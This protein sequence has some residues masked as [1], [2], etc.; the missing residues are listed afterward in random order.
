[1]G[2]NKVTPNRH[3][4]VQ[5]TKLT[6]TKKLYLDGGS[7][8]YIV[9]SLA[10]AVGFVVGGATL[11]LLDE[12]GS[13]GNVVI[14]KAACAGFTKIA[15]TFSDDSILST[16]G[17]HDT[18]IDF[19]HS[20]KISLAVTANIT[21]LNLIFPNVSGNFLLLLTYDGDHTITNY[22]VY[23]NDESAADGSADVL[24]PGGTKPDNTASGVDILSF[25]YD[26]IPGADKCYGVASLAFAT[27]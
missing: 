4:L 13:D 10:D 6:A 17:T 19:R 16:G 2:S 1:M 18:H 9:E 25:F 3:N 7:D 22:K 12:N 27:P 21:N 11:M 15:E 20:N 24:W 8:T 14:F 23:E 26:P 5:D